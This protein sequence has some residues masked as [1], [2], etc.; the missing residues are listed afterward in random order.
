VFG[1]IDRVLLIGT[2]IGMRGVGL[3][4]ATPDRLEELVA[5]RRQ[6]GRTAKELAIFV[7]GGIP[8]HTIFRAGYCRR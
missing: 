4:P 7:D 2:A 3:D 5:H 6:A 8:E 1:E